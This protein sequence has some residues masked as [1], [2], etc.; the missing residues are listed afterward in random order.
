MANTNE[1]YAV[2]IDLGT[3]YSCVGV[4]QHGQVEIISNDQGY[5]TT[6]SYV[7][8]TDTDRLVGE[9]A[10]SQTSMNPENTIFDAKRLIGRTF[11]D[12]TVQKD[13]RT[14]PF[15]VV[16]G[17]DNRPKVGVKFK[18]EEKEYFAEEISSMVLAYL[19]K[20]AETYLGG[21]V[22][23]AVITVPAYFNDSQRNATKD[24]GKM[25]GLE[26]LRIINEPTAA[27]L[28]YGLSD[29]SH[30]DEKVLIFDLGGGTFDVSLLE[31]QKD[32]ESGNV[33]EVLATAGDTHLGGEDFDSNMV[34][35][36]IQEFKKKNRGK[37]MSDDPRAL[38]RLRSA[39]ERAKR[40]L[41][42][43]TQAFIE[44]DALYD[45][46]DFNS[47][48]TR[49]KFEELNSSLFN[50]TLKPVEQVLR[51]AKVSKT[52]VDK[53]VLV[54]G[55]T[56]IPQIQKLLS[57]FFGGKELCKSVNPD[58]A[59]AYGATIQA[60]ILSGT[61]DKDKEILIL[62]VSPLSLG[63]ETAG[64]VMT[65]LIPRNTTIPT[66]KEQ[67]FSTYS[68]NQTGVLIQVYEGERPATKN[69]NLLGKFHLDGFPPMA[70]GKPQIVVS[71][72]LDA[73][74]TLTVTAKETSSG[75]MQDIKIKND[76]GRLSKADIDRM[77]REAEE[78][79][80]ED[81]EQQKRIK[82][83][84]ELENYVYGMKSALDS[85]GLEK[86]ESTVL[87]QAKTLVQEAMT[88]LDNNPSSP[89]EDY[90]AKKK[91]FD[92]KL[93]PLMTELQKNAS[94]NEDSG[95]PGMG[96]PGMG[97]STQDEEEEGPSIEEVD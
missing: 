76:S 53:I 5:R 36:F 47:T 55:S 90:E 78:H 7:A 71:Y 60:A 96:M 12:P 33:F 28:A 94:P 66:K 40:T 79:R 23:K 69:N 41:S 21:P 51:D 16:A 20:T 91:E 18:G 48:I 83:K 4:W 13:M 97:P 64:G 15:K 84:S 34:N 89:V 43:S 86:S 88:W 45:K 57:E 81:E 29:N 82:S 39:C 22:S 11:D 73:N 72:D 50:G 1:G 95:M 2:G 85:P 31:I 3:T 49:A 61:M 59:V 42:T 46:I 24:A 62:D 70:R 35:H 52:D 17:K 6:P 58:E 80:A 44:V 9:S 74:G 63:I 32:E 68:D 10:K 93:M 26:V 38:R 87:E 54:G 19:K 92:E 30:G 14:W 37:D 75:K 65:T 67:T 27:S 25:A 8:F 77:L 56:R